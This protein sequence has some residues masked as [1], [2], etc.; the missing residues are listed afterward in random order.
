MAEKKGNCI[1]R[2]KDILNY[3]NMTGGFGIPSS[4]IRSLAEKFQVTERQIYKDIEI[5]I[6][7]ISLPKIEKLSK[8]FILSFEISMKSVHRLII[9]PDLNIQAKGIALLNQTISNFT[10]FLEKFGLKKRVADILEVSEGGIDKETFKVYQEL[11][12]KYIQTFKEKNEER[13]K[14]REILK[15]RVGEKLF[16]EIFK[17]IEEEIYNK[18]RLYDVIPIKNKEGIVERVIEINILKNEEIR[19]MK[20]SQQS[21][22]DLT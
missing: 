20:D 12:D 13:G 4:I 15:K 21:Q 2:R 3:L 14:L 18:R 11:A 10:D 5:V 16:E 6:Q 7:K 19:K 1:E 9:S 17:E 8:K 22:E